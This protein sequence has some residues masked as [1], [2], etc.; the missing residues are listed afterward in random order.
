MI[1]MINQIAKQLNLF[2]ITDEK[3]KVLINK[4]VRN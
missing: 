3:L 4:K 1:D 2:E